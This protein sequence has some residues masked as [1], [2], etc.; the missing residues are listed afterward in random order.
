[1]SEPQSP[2]R[3]ISKADVL[4]QIPFSVATMWREIAADRFPKPIRIGARRIAFF[5]DEIDEWLKERAAQRKAKVPAA[6]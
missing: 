2:R 1:M 5:Q 4:T 3:L 6:A